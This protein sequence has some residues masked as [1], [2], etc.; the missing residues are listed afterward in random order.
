MGRYAEAGHTAV[1]LSKPPID[2]VFET[3]SAPRHTKLAKTR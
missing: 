1:K 3:Y 2:L